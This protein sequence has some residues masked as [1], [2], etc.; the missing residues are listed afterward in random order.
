MMEWSL[1]SGK[2]L[3]LSSSQPLSICMPQNSCL[4][5]QSSMHLFQHGT[6]PHNTTSLNAKQRS[7]IT[8]NIT[9]HTNPTRCHLNVI[10]S[11]SG[12]STKANCQ[13]RLSTP[14]RPKSDGRSLQSA[15][16]TKRQHVTPPSNANVTIAAA[17]S[18]PNIW[19]STVVQHIY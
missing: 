4:S 7:A 14:P 2:G 9:C 18:D 13:S 6:H 11:S 8:E 5:L 1:T 12:V 10:T 15:A 17:P 19:R 16:T 3:N